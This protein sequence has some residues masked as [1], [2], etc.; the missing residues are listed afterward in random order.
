MILEKYELSE[1]EQPTTKKSRLI[2]LAM[3]KSFFLWELF[4]KRHNRK[5]I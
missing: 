5:K 4:E 1:I 3:C 2:T